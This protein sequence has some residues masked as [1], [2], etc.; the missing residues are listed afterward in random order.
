[1][2]TR[3]WSLC[4]RQ[5]EH[6]ELV[7]L[8]RTQQSYN[9]SCLTASSRSSLLDAG[10]SHPIRFRCGV[11]ADGSCVRQGGTAG[12]QGT[13]CALP[14]VK[15]TFVSGDDHTCE[16]QSNAIAPKI[17]AA[18]LSSLVFQMIL[19]GKPTKKQAPLWAFPQVE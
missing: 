7:A 1:M 19:G 17:L 9:Y 11:L 13:S 14:G 4:S 3:T 10:I 8:S 16:M 15:H 2:C 12:T 18:K 6:N 5:R